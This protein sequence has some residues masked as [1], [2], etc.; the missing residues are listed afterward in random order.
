MSYLSSGI[1]E[2]AATPELS[3]VAMWGES[4]RLIAFP[5]F[6]SAQLTNLVQ[7]VQPAYTSLVHG[8]PPLPENEW[9]TDAIR[10]LNERTVSDLR[11]TTHE[12]VS[13]FDYKAT[14]DLLCG[15]YVARNMFDRL[16]LAP[17]GSKMQAVAVGLFRAVVQDVQIVY[18]IPKEFAESGRYTRGVREMY[19]LDLPCDLT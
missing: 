3:S 16:V 15:I 2:V 7:E 14:L 11:E 8:V 1:F 18:P 17:T 6:D 4:I 13:T 5:S 9:R 12:F 10:R 19:Q